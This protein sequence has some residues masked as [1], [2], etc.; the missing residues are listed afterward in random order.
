MDSSKKIKV[1]ING[2]GRIGRAFLKTAM[3]ED[4]FKNR[5]EISAVNDLGDADNLAYLLKYD[6]AYGPSGLSVAAED[7]FLN[8]DGKKIRFLQIKDPS[9]LPWKDMEIDVVVESTGVFDSYEKSKVHLVAGAKRVV[10][11]APVKDNPADSGVA[12]ATVLMGLN[13]D[14]LK[15][16]SISSNASCT[17]NAASPIIAI[18]QETIGI[19]KALLNTVHAYTATQ[20]LVDS[21][22]KKDFRRGRAAAQNISPSSTGAAIAVTKVA[23]ELENFFDGIAIRVPVVTGSIVDLTFIAKR[24]TDTAEV[25]NILKKAASEDRWKNIFTTTEEQLVS[26][27]VIGSKYGSIADLNFTRVVGG[28]LVKILAWYDNEVGYTYTLA[29]HVV[30]TGEFIGQ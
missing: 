13:D 10:V 16:C 6:T 5:L 2:L 30:R 15:T 18:M 9:M 24:N 29:D 7:G 22:A 1:A 28:N 20:S 11:S 3:K 23:T 12:G 14:A 19:E 4:R 25:N 8:I 17:T 26:S 21:P 27:D